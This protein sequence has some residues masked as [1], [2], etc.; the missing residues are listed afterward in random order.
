MVKHYLKIF[1]IFCVIGPILEWAYGKFWSVV[2]QSPW[3]Y[4]SSPFEYTSLEGIPLWGLGGVLAAA[5]THA[6]KQNNPRH[7]IVFAPTT[8]LAVIWI[9][10]YSFLS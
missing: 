2:G 3:L 4:P 1:A 8:V 9:L 7:L 5:V 6:I 10:V